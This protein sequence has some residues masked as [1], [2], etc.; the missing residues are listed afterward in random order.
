MKFVYKWTECSVLNKT[1]PT[2][3][4]LG[5]IKEEREWKECKAWST[6]RKALK[7]LFLGR[8]GPCQ[9]RSHSRCGCLY[10]ICTRMGPSVV[11]HRWGWSLGSHSPFQ[12]NYGLMINSGRSRVTGETQTPKTTSKLMVKQMAQVKPSGSQACRRKG[13]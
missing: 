5:E 4:K 11:S 13:S 2:P 3:Q 8:T 6:D 10:W 1:I 9:S 12:L 7:C